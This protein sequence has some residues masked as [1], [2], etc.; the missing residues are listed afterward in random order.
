MWQHISGRYAEVLNVIAKGFTTQVPHVLEE[1]PFTTNN[2][3]STN[4]RATGVAASVPTLS[5]LY[6]VYRYTCSVYSCIWSGIERRHYIT[7]YWW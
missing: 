5:N 1:W 3:D 7:R 6:T 2:L 4:V